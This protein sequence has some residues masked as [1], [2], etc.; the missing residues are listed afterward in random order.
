MASSFAFFN[1]LI[2]SWY[3]VMN[4]TFSDLPIGNDKVSYVRKQEKQCFATCH[5]ISLY[6]DIYR[7]C[8]SHPKSPLA[9]LHQHYN[10]SG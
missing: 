5:P 6:A 1:G 4:I 3:S 9:E 2:A 7:Q 10:N 8:T